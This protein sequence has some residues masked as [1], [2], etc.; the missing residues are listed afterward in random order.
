MKKSTEQLMQEFQDYLDFNCNL[1]HTARVQNKI[2][3][4]LKKIIDG[5]RDTDQKTLFQVIDDIALQF[6]YYTDLSYSGIANDLKSIWLEYY[7][8][9]DDL[10]LAEQI[11]AILSAM[12]DVKQIN[13][14][15]EF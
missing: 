6:S 14:D 13:I 8:Q 3:V 2:Y 12:F 10:L 11:E 1:L 4:Q 15:V 9:D 5:H 7:E